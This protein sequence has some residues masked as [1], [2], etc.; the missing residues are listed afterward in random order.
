MKNLT[1]LLKLSVLFSAKAYDF[2]M[3]TH[4]PGS[5]LKRFIDIV[6]SASALILFFPLFL[7]VSFGIRM[8][9][10]GPVFYFARRGGIHGKNFSMCKFRTM[11]IGSD[12]EG[13]ITSP[14][15]LR[16][17]PFG[18]FLRR[19]K[20][21]E[22]PQLWNVFIGEMSL[23]GPRPEDPM[24]INL[25]Y[26][27]WMFETLKIKPGITGPGA[28][29]GYLL[30]DK[31]LSEQ[32]PTGSYVANLLHP[33]LS[34]ELAYMHRS[35]LFNDFIYFILTV[36]AIFSSVFGFHLSIPSV[37]VVAARR[38]CPQLPLI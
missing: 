13:S 33:K 14:N 16:V 15:D 17:F 29:Y 10:P 23:V 31:F 1:L 32:D 35:N 27:E 38:W 34:L 30:G 6:F 4:S 24:I 12:V 20:I 37:D 21:D 18:S 11:Y 9:S 2:F 28:I 7:L 36:F 19:L 22:L 3:F 25:F 5:F 26:T 8:T